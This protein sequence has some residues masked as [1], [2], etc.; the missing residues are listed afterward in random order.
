MKQKDIREILFTALSLFLICAVSAGIL[1]AVNHKTDPI[2][3]TRSEETARAAR[4]EL[5]PDAADFEE[6]ALA[7]GSAA[8]AG[9]DADGVICGYV[10]TTSASSYGGK[11]KLMTGISAAGA[12]TGVKILEI[13][14]TPGLGMNAKRP[15]FLAQYDGTDAELTVVKNAEAGDNEIAAITSATITS[16]A[17]TAAV[18]AARAGFNELTGEAA[19]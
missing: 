6:V 4:S 9:T 15:E 1:A 17:V 16:R 14:D 18:N 13:E 11:L 8:D 7:D 19:S 5:L 2:I 3:R 10:F 12:V